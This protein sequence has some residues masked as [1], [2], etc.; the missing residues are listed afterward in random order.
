MFKHTKLFVPAVLAAGA[1]LLTA[2]G[3]DVSA[4]DGA[5]STTPTGTDSS[6]KGDAAPAG[7]TEGE[8]TPAGGGS[9]DGVENCGNSAVNNGPTLLL[10]PDKGAGGYLTCDQLRAVWDEFTSIAARGEI[11]AEGVT[12]DSDW[13][14]VPKVDNGDMVG[15]DCFTPAVPDANNP[16]E[17]KFH[18]EP[19]L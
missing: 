17:L 2:C 8:S 10:V 6:T 16:V 9:T 13:Q 11:P 7:S 14:C 3:P 12:V 1:L 19:A 15:A 4:D 5:K 18:A